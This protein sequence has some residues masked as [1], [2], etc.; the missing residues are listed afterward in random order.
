MPR[1]EAKQLL[2]EESRKGGNPK[3]VRRLLREH[4]FRQD[5]KDEAI[6]IAS[7]YKNENTMWELRIAGADDNTKNGQLLFDAIRQDDGGK[8]ETL[9]EGGNVPFTEGHIS[10][11]RQRVNECPHAFGVLKLLGY[12]P[13]YERTANGWQY[14]FSCSCLDQVF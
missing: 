8:V 12:M 9:Y 3:R 1:S 10:F 6:R 2:L 11:A 14:N 13:G 5:T 7:H 4:L